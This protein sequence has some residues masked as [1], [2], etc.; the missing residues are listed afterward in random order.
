MVFRKAGELLVLTNL[1]TVSS[2]LHY[3][4]KKV[5]LLSLVLMNKY[6]YVSIYFL[7]KGCTVI[8]GGADKYL[9]L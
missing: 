4:V 8:R 7:N 1:E 5:H 6:M 9:V 2:N 3:Y